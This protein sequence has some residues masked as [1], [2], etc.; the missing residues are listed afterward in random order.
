MEEVPEEFYARVPMQLELSGRFHQLA[1]FF[2][3]VGQLERIIN[4]ENI[5][6]TTPTLVDEEIRLKTKV[7]ATAFHALDD[8]A[9]DP[10]TATRK[11]RDRR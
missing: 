10:E 1:K 11:R 7:L 8:A 4:L 9:E 2:Y 6:I 5:S 3:N